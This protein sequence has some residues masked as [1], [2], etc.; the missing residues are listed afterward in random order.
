MAPRKIKAFTA[1]TLT[2]VTFR[3]RKKEKKSLEVIDLN[4]GGGCMGGGY[5]ML[6]KLRKNTGFIRDTTRSKW[7]IDIFCCFKNIPP[8]LSESWLYE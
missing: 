4:Q 2:I 6:H 7:G 8:P 1:E 3:G 5:E